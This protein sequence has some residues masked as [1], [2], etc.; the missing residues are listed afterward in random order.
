MFSE[1]KLQMREINYRLI[2]LAVL[3]VSATVKVWSQMPSVPVPSPETEAAEDFT[4]WYVSL[5][6]LGLGLAGAIFWWYSKKKT[7]K[8]A[9]NKKKKAVTADNSWEI[10]ALDANKEM[11]WLRKNHKIMGAKGGKKVPVRRKS[12]NVPTSENSSVKVKVEVKSLLPL[13]IFSIDKL[14]PAR[15]I[16]QLMLSNDP[17]LISAVEQTQDEFEED[18]A[19]R[20]LAVRILNAFRTRNSIE[21]LSQVAL[22]DLSSNLRSKAVTILSDF[23]H[24][25]VF[26]TILLACADPTREVRAAAARGLT[27]LSCDR[28][29]AWT[30]IVETEEEGRMVQAARAAI[31]GDMVERFF[32]R[33]IHP[34]LKFAYEGFALLALLIKANETKAIFKALENHEDLTVRRAIL[35]VIKVTKNQK[36]MEGLYSLLER[37]VLPIELQEEVDKTIEEMGFVTV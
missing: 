23:D 12:I 20:E 21:A 10:G 29:D 22:Y 11:E 14:K 1:N 24:E 25:T 7:E 35:H 31:E 36:A 3:L 19:V 17:A 28:A 32:N 6:V 26:S 30:R 15:P 4:W 9:K 2:N 27:R 16:E 8:S 34:D 5:F 37:N 33:L 18:E 13:P